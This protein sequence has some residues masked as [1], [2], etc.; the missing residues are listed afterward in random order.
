VRAPSSVLL[1]TARDGPVDRK[2][3]DRASASGAVARLMAAACR[4]SGD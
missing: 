2:G 4:V 1:A 3:R